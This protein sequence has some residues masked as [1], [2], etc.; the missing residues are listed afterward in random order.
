[1][2]Q[3]NDAAWPKDGSVKSTKRT[4][5]DINLGYVFNHKILLKRIDRL[6]HKIII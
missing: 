4:P 6:F 3:S 1:L 5:T 2:A